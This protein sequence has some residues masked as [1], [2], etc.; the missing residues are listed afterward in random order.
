MNRHESSGVGNQ[1][2]FSLI[3]V[4]AAITIIAALSGAVLNIFSTAR[5][6]EMML[7][8]DTQARLL[9]ESGMNYASNYAS[10]ILSGATN[11]A[12]TTLDGRVITTGLPTNQKITLSVSVSASNAYDYVVTSVGTVNAGTKFEANY[13]VTNVINAPNSGTGIYIVQSKPGTAV[14]TPTGVSVNASSLNDYTAGIS[15]D[16]RFAGSG[17]SIASANFTNGIGS[18]LNGFRV[19]FT[20][21]ISSG[22]AADG[23]VFSIKNGTWNTPRDAGGPP[24]GV[25]HGSFLGYA[26]PGY[27]YWGNGLGIRPPKMGVEFDIYTNSGHSGSPT[28]SSDGRNDPDNHHIANIFWGSTWTITTAAAAPTNSY[29]TSSYYGFDDNVHNLGYANDKTDYRPFNPDG[30]DN[31]PGGSGR[32]GL[33][34]ITRTNMVGTASPVPVRIEVIRPSSVV[35]SVSTDAHY[36]MYAYVIKTWHNCTG[37]GCNDISTDY[38][39]ATPTIQYTV[40]M[41]AAEHTMFQF[42]VFGFQVSTG[43]STG[44]YNFSIPKIGMR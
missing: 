35:S 3:W 19:Y 40:Y 16:P 2:G 27:P 29:A 23:F 5:K 12:L 42:F 36:N 6:N 26:G 39:G 11:N 18:L 1:G 30:T 9:A 7:T 43:A 41:T 21:S 44:Q 10:D 24:A 34:S 32:P 20:Y 31:D 15:F 17:N 25:S 38:A 28:V 4:I 22:S 8:F 33:L 14:A 13:S 37:V